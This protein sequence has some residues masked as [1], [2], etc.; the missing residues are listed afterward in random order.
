MLITLFGFVY[1][2]VLFYPSLVIGY[3]T[4]YDTY[5][6][7][8][9]AYLVAKGGLQ[10]SPASPI[11]PPL[12]IV[13]VAA[14][15]QLTGIDPLHLIMPIGLIADLL[16]I[17]PMYYITKKIS[18][19]N[20]TMGFFAAFLVPLN[21]IGTY[22]VIMGTIPNLLGFL[23]FLL[24]VC[25]L[26]SDLRPKPIGILLMALLE[27]FVFYV[28]LLVTAFLAFFVALI[29]VYEILLRRGS[30]YFKPLLFSLFISVPVAA[31]YYLPRIG[32][33]YL[34]TIGGV[35]YLIWSLDNVIALPIILLPAINIFHSSHTKRFIPAKNEQ[36][37]FLRLWYLS[38]PLI[39][40]LF[41]WQ[42]A[43]SNRMWH[44][45]SYPAIIVLAMIV[46]M[47]LTRIKKSGK[48]RTATIAATA[49]LIAAFTFSF[50]VSATL[51]TEFQNATPQRLQVANWIEANTS[52]NAR[53]CTEEEYLANHLGWF[54]MGTTGRLAYESISNFREPYEVGIDVT[55]NLAL[56]NNITTLQAGS[57]YWIQALKALNVTY[58][59]LLAANSHPNYASISNGTVFTNAVYVIYNVTKYTLMP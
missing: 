39:A 13:L 47:W 49:F 32:F 1:M 18:G 30:R 58:V 2:M 52:L 16:S 37:S 46:P 54:I 12:F 19:G 20:E 14:L 35:D 15:Y 9:S 28:H 7:A 45:A 41:I 17:P 51:T 48:R 57:T 43:I 59:I 50:S 29:F 11:Y 38:P 53:F 26:I 33:F 42:A 5:I 31:I 25:V 23:G 22:L 27:I 44:F 8:G 56:A 4:G 6:H 21:P 55:R 40:V 36:L 10:A 34:G 3:P 24:I